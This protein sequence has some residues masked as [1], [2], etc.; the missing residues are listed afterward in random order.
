[1]NNMNTTFFRIF[2]VGA[3]ALLMA[4]CSQKQTESEKLVQQVMDEVITRLYA[5][6]NEEELEAIDQQNAMSLF[7]EEDLKVLSTRHWVFD[8][9]VPV[10]VSLMRSKSQKIMPFWIESSGF[11]KTGLEMRNDYHTY[12]VWQ[13]EF[14]RGT[15]ELGINGFEN[16][17]YHYFVAVAPQKETKNLQLSN[18]IPENQYVG[19]LDGGAFTYHDWTELVLQDVP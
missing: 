3:F 14:G 8:V 4:G 13:K 7:S 2:F 9:N 17:A 1:M 18:F 19:V 10:V 6:M 11:V 12:E 5:T 15:V 16:F